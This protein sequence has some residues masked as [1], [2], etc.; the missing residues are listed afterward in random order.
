MGSIPINSKISVGFDIDNKK[1]ISV[2]EKIKIW[3]F[4]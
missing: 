1:M 4:N 3:S 2:D